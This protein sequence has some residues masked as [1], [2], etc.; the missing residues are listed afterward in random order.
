VPPCSINAQGVVKGNCKAVEERPEVTVTQGNGNPSVPTVINDYCNDLYPG[1]C[2]EPL[3]P[4]VC[5]TIEKICVPPPP[6]EECPEKEE[7]S[8]PKG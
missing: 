8:G 3:P 1:K 6:E 4:S 2:L 7:V 5:D